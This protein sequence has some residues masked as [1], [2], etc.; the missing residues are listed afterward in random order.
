MRSLRVEAWK[1]WKLV[2]VHYMI[3]RLKVYE[4]ARQSQCF[5]SSLYVIL[6]TKTQV[7][8]FVGRYFCLLKTAEN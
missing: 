7:G 6:R 4:I 5:R 3:A 8:L 1:W 2:A